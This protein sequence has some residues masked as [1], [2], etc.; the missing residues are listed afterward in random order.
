MLPEIK[1]ILYTTNLQDDTRPVLRFAVSLAK[2][3]NAKLTLLHVVEPLSDASRFMVEAYLSESMAEQLRT[4][5]PQHVLDK[6]HS[7]LERFCAEE[8]NTNLDQLDFIGEIKVIPGTP[9]EI[10]A[11]EAEALDVDL[12]V[13]GR[14]HGSKLRHFF[15]GSTAQ[16]VTLISRKPVLIVPSLEGASWDV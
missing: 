10:I 7:R 12:I 9:S 13:A 5:I 15:L 1:K 14:G 11:R 6:I 4:E 8:L 3:H 2:T 16:R